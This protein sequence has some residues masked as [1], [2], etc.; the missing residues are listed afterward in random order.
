MKASGI[1]INR[2]SG[3]SDISGGKV[4]WR[5]Q[6]TEN[7]VSCIHLFHRGMNRVTGWEKQVLEGW[8]HSSRCILLF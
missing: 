7:T 4:Y 6:E 5:R 8:Q 1:Q 2:V 3:I